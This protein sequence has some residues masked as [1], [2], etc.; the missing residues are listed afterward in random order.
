MRLGSS[1]MGLH[2]LELKPELSAALA[3]GPGCPGAGNRLS[4][5]QGPFLLPWGE[6]RGCSSLGTEGGGEW[7]MEE[8]AEGKGDACAM[9]K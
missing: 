4:R 7:M 1:S 5:G 8:P 3:L 9:R 6:G 2:G